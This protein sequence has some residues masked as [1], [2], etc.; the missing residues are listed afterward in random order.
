M[1][2]DMNGRTERNLAVSDLRVFVPSS[3][4]GMSHAFYSALG[5]QHDPDR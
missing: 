2:A 5:Y 3:N 1:V 4:F